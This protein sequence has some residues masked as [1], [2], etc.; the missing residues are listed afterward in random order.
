MIAREGFVPVSA[1]VVLCGA[2]TYLGGP[3]W[4]APLWVLTACMLYLFREGEAQVPA[5]PLGVVS[6][7][8]GRIR[9]VDRVRDPWL[10]RDVL[11][12]RIGFR[13]PGIACV[14]SPVEGKVVDYRTEPV[15][16]EASSP[17]P[18][19]RRGSPNCYAVHVRTDEADDVLFAVSS[20][21]PVSRFRL[22]VAPGERIGQGQGHGFAYFASFVDVLV[23]A[24]SVPVSD[25][26]TP[27]SAGTTV[28]ATLVHD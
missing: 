6:P 8:D 27:A 23:P 24:A 19:S 9:R 2:V 14:R 5:L 15:A 20:V 26:E 1:A 12:I 18:A 10:E 13:F 11:R 7:I 28:L 21:Y 22:R 17:G 25:P 16:F 4:G 3:V